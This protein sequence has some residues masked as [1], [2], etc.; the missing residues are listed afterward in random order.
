MQDKWGVLVHGR[1]SL[2]PAQIDEEEGTSDWDVGQYTLNDFP[3]ELIGEEENA[4]G[5][6]DAAAGRAVF[7]HLLNKWTELVAVKTSL[8]G[9]S[10]WPFSDL[11]RNAVV[12]MMGEK[13]E[14]DGDEMT[15]YNNGQFY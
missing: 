4:D 9:I 5:C 3:E 8:T 11:K 12:V 7:L 13:E 1:P 10:Y 14:E 2:I 6:V 15:I